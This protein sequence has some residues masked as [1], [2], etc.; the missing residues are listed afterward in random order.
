V[1]SRSFSSSGEAEVGVS[2]SRLGVVGFRLVV[3][4]EGA[5]PGDFR[6]EAYSDFAM[7]AFW[8][9]FLHWVWPRG[10]ILRRIWS[11][12]QAPSLLLDEDDVFVYPISWA[13]KRD[14]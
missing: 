1:G 2:S 11:V 14:V 6:F 5:F 8:N 13:A 4:V 10:G 3:E 12:F 7:L 9:R